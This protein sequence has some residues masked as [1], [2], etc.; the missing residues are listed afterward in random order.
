MGPQRLLGRN[1]R[2]PNMDSCCWSSLQRKCPMVEGT[3]WDRSEVSVTAS[4]TGHQFLQEKRTSMGLEP[5]LWIRNHFPLGLL[6]VRKAWSE[7]SGASFGR[8]SLEQGHRPPRGIITFHRKRCFPL[9]LELQH[10]GSLSIPP[11]TSTCSIFPKVTSEQIQ[12]T[13]ATWFLNW[14]HPSSSKCKVNII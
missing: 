12:L 11:Q 9:L 7:M 2:E 3:P 1:N 6:W 10:L 4:G 14:A 8:C 13:S 5:S